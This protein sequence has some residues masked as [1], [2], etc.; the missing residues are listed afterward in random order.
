[1]NTNIILN[2]DSY[3]TSHWLQYPPNTETVFSYI[4]SRGG[5]YD[6]GKRSKKGR[7]T[8]YQDADGNIFTG[9]RDEG[10]GDADLLKTVYF[11]GKITNEY[12]FEEIRE[13]AEAT[14]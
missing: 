3:K 13:Q 11:N 14:T 5:K 9:K 2:T 6:S 7:I 4:E 8:L 12:S 10:N 1:M